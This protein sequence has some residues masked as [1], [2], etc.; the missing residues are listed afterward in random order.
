MAEPQKNVLQQLIDWTLS[1]KEP[2]EWLRQRIGSLG[3]VLLV[4][5]AAVIAAC[6]YIWSNW[7]DIKERPGIKPLFDWLTRKPIPLAPAGRLTIAVACL[8]NDKDQEHEKLLL[9]ELRHFEGVETVPVPR[10]VDPDQ[11]DKKK[12]EEEARGLLRETGADV[13]ISGNVISLSGKSYMRLY[14]TPSRDLS[15]AKA[16]ERYPAAN[17]DHRA[18]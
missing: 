14:W 9:D 2:F 16:S 5:I 12:N 3:A 1:W 17:R 8:C 10:R 6:F 7:K 15:G 4:L 11:P 18:A 13:L